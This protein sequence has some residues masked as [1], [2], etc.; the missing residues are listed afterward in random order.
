[1]S[2]KITFNEKQLQDAISKGK[3]DFDY[4]YIRFDEEFEVSKKYINENYFEWDNPVESQ[5]KGKTYYLYYVDKESLSERQVVLKYN[6]DSKLYYLEL[7]NPIEAED[8][9]VYHKIKS[10]K[11]LSKDTKVV[12]D[13]GLI[14]ATN[15]DNYIEAIKN[16]DFDY[17]IIKT[18][19]DGWQEVEVKPQTFT[20]EEFY[21][22][23]YINKSSKYHFDKP[24][25]SFKDNEI[26]ITFWHSD[27]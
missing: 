22:K 8:G 2:D 26:N 15:S 16:L 18:E 12:A 3:M 5:Y 1:M 23:Y 24:I 13:M 17:T 14:Y 21:N 10:K 25:I 9:F 27:K 4:E 20:I 7:F 19:I 6:A 11:S